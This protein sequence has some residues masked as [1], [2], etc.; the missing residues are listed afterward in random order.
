MTILQDT[1]EFVARPADAVAGLLPDR[2]S[3][4]AAVAAL[5]AAGFAAVESRPWHPE[6]CRLRDWDGDAPLMHLYVA[7]LHQGRSLVL[8]PAARQQRREIGRV[9]MRHRGRAVYYFSAVGV[10][11]LAVLV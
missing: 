6:R 1:P 2:Q 3:A 11:S 10:E 7:G 8:V 9:L 4:R 5:H